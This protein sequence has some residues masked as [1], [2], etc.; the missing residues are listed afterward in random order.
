MNHS[1]ARLI[2]SNL[3][4]RIEPS[5]DGLFRLEGVITKKE[6]E[7]L[8]LMIA[9]SS[10]ESS[11]G[12]VTTGATSTQTGLE[13]TSPTNESKLDQALK[14]FEDDEVVL[15][16]SVFSLPESKN[17]Y[18][19]CLDFGTAMSKATFVS[20]NEEA[21]FEDIRVLRLG[22]PGNQEEVDEFMLISS[23]F[24]DAEGLIWFGQN[25]I[26]R[27]HDA[28]E[29][30]GARIDNIKRWLSEGNL[31]TAV[32]PTNNPTAF[33]ITYEDL[34]LAYLSFFTWAVNSSIKEAAAEFN[35]PKNF[36]RRFAMPCF[37]RA[38]AKIVEH[39][40]MELLGEAQIIADT[41]S[42]EI[43][44][45]LPIAKFLAAAQQV[46]SIKRSYNFIEGSITEPLGVAGSLLS[47]KASH[48]SLALV[49]DIGAGT[50]DFSL[51]RLQ[52]T[53]DEDGEVDKSKTIAM[54]VEGSARG[55]TQAGNHLDRILKGFILSRASIS[56]S[57]PK[58]TNIA[59]DLERNIR[60]YKEAL[61]NTGS[62]FI[63]LYNDDSVEISLSEFLEHD[64]VKEFEVFLQKT[65][66][67]VLESVSPDFMNW[68]RVNPARSLIV[69]LTGGGASLPM[70]KKL[71]I[72]S[73]LVNGSLV[74]LAP[75]QAFPAWLQKDYPDLEDSYGRIAVSL[76]G[77]RKNV[78]QSMGVVTITG[79]GLGGHVLERF[80]TRGT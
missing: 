69:V 63:V 74:S 45:G 64:A 44:D 46:R 70:A 52:L 73:V 55:I 30:G 14:S 36:R 68:V 61:F 5:K 60:D 17:N 41:F 16:L 24:I 6:I 49:V 4:E 35:V 78:I 1:T 3:R 28:P 20:E 13:A 31:S 7:A 77:A 38:N 59:Y 22:V 50:S 58:F 27:A 56:S 9:D 15:D 42:G 67:D 72:G 75:A 48:D 51:Y 62:V 80:P 79:T 65:Q 26:E 32:E 57:H 66:M 47:W 33:S 34:I 10:N 40:L 19:V 21:D 29:D 25:A 71:A 23:I 11:G 8:D 2:L 43:H 39:K 53:A 54:E 37:P 18:R 12:A 76:G